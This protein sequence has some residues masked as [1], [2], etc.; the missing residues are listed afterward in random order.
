MPRPPPNCGVAVR[1]QPLVIDQHDVAGDPHL[2]RVPAG[3][4]L[5]PRQAASAGADLRH[6]R[7]MVPLGWRIW[8]MKSVVP[9]TQTWP[10]PGQSICAR[11]AALAFARATLSSPPGQHD[12]AGRGP[13]VLLIEGERLQHR[14]VGGDEEDRRVAVE[15]VD[16]LAPARRPGTAS[17][18]NGAQS[19]RLPSTQGVA[20]SLRRERRA[21]WRSASAAASFRPAAASA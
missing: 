14:L 17:V 16:M 13:A 6:R 9:S 12:L 11:M 3:R 19:K 7:S 10:P 15:L 2:V 4:Q 8:P 5:D 21:G 20:A 1:A 18:S